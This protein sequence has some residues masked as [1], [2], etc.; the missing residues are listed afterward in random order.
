MKSLSEFTTR[1]KIADFAG[2]IAFD[3]DDRDFY[4]GKHKVKVD[5]ILETEPVISVGFKCRFP[6]YTKKV[7]TAIKLRK[8]NNKLS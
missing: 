1:K 8:L 4:F 2:M 5:K 7:L 3:K 6:L